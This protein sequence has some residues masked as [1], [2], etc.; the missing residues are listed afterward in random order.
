M[1][2]SPTTD[3]KTTLSQTTFPSHLTIV[4]DS[5][6]TKMPAVTAF[7][8]RPTFNGTKNKVLAM[9][10]LSYKTTISAIRRELRPRGHFLRDY[11]SS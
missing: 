7:D 2:H 8:Y 9:F 6:K 10:L 5:L 4:F 3:S 1:A 11:D